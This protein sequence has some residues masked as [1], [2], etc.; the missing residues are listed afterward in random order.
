[1]RPDA[2][3]V[4]ASMRKGER[5]FER[6]ASICD[7][8]EPLLEIDRAAGERAWIRTQPNGT[9]FVTRDPFDT[10]NFPRDHPHHGRP[11]YHWGRPRRDG[12]TLGYL[13]EEAQ[14]C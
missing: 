6:V 1:M 8:A 10:L 3:L 5:V 9:L 4:P 7:V 2:L 11:R 12:I 14:A 13:V